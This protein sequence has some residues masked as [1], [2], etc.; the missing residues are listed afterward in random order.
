LNGI[1]QTSNTHYMTLY[2][3]F[4]KLVGLHKNRWHDVTDKLIRSESHKDFW[5]K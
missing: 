4:N 5:G 2:D 1:N 3:M